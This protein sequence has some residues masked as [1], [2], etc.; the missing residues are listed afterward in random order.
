MTVVKLKASAI[1]TEKSYCYQFK[2]FVLT[3]DHWGTNA[4]YKFDCGLY[5]GLY[6]KI[7]EYCKSHYNNIF[8][9][10]LFYNVSQV[11]NTPLTSI[12]IAKAVSNI[13]FFSSLLPVQWS[14]L[15]YMVLS[16]E[17][18]TQGDP[19]AMPM[20]A[21]GVKSFNTLTDDFIQSFKIEGDCSIRV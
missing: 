6:L 8:I 15:A 12:R 19:L 4:D 13:T 9:Y 7:S 14:Y 10:L 16:E 2:F 20:Y 11:L 3:L 1:V 5:E 18:T 21:S 17:G